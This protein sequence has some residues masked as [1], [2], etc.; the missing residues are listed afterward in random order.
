[1]KRIL[2]ILFV[3]LPLYVAA[4]MVQPVHWSGEDRGDS[5]R[6]RATVDEGWHM[7]I[8]EMGEFMFT[9]EYK[10]SFVMTVAKTE[11]AP[12]RFNACNDV[13]CTA[14]EVWDYTAHATS[15]DEPIK[16]EKLK[17]QN[18]DRSLWLIFLLGLLGGLLAIFT[19][20]V[21][22][23]IPMT[24]SFFLKKGGGLKDAVLYG[25]SIVIL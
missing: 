18:G 5:V 20:C 12:I 3:C 14:P 4:Q 24:V 13:M 19:P 1:M 25:L 11:M 23:I 8:L 17:I 2:F 9:Q 16:N 7:S 15:G 6:I 10:D 21:W 22:P